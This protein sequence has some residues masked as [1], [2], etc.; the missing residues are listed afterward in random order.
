MYVLLLAST[1]EPRELRN[2]FDL[3]DLIS[4]LY[5]DRDRP[6]IGYCDATQW[7]LVMVRASRGQDQAAKSSAT[8][9]ADCE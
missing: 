4:G 2:T 8:P 5:R 1:N 3:G 9:G 6:E 7:I